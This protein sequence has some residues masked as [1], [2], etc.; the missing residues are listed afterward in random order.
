VMTSQIIQSRIQVNRKGENSTEGVL[1]FL[2]QEEV[3]KLLW[4]SKAS[5]DRRQSFVLITQGIFTEPIQFDD[6]MMVELDSI[7]LLRIEP[8]LSLFNNKAC[9]LSTVVVKTSTDLEW[10]ELWFDP[11]DSSS[12]D[13]PVDVL[14]RLRS[15]VQPYNRDFTTMELDSNQFYLTEKTEIPQNLNLSRWPEGIP[16]PAENSNLFKL[17]SFGLNVVSTVLGTSTANVI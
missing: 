4:V 14:Y 9:C 1:A 8:Q 17:G 7:L 16:R 12:I 10:Q 11:I 2:K 6:M 13:S 5:L 15:W 3:L